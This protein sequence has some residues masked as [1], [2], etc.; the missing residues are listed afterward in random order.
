[1]DGL[2][3]FLVAICEY[4]NKGIFMKVNTLD[5]LISLFTQQASQSSQ[6]SRSGRSGQSGQSRKNL[7][8]MTPEQALILAFSS[9]KEITQA[10]TW[11]D[12]LVQKINQFKKRP[13][14]NLSNASPNHPTNHPSGFSASLSPVLFHK[15]QSSLR[16]YADPEKTKLGEAGIKLLEELVQIKVLSLSQ[17]EILIDQLMQLETD[18]IPLHHL[19][20]LLFIALAADV[21]SAQQLCWLDC[22]VLKDH[23]HKNN[24]ALH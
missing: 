21:R 13:T 24:R 6:S 10:V 7:N 1:M 5:I 19:R 15:I 17:R 14:N 18:E 23:Q 9:E 2:S 4:A 16:I 11:L 22:L 8:L 3:K 12:D 20:W